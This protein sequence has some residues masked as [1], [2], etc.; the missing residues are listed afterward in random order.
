MYIYTSKTITLIVIIHFG[1]LST[2]IIGFKALSNIV[3]G[4]V[5]LVDNEILD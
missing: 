5:L 2:H 4:D 3:D 1:Y